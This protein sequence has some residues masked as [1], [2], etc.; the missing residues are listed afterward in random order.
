MAKVIF[1]NHAAVVVSRQEQ[2]TIRAFYCGVLGFKAIRQTDDKDDF[3][4]GDDEYFHITIL[5]GEFAD[6]SEFLRSGR[7]IYLELKADD[8]E[9]MR[10]KIIDS[11]VRT[12]E[13]PDPHLYFQA[14]GGQ[15]FRL[16]GI[17]EELTKYERD[18]VGDEQRNEELVAAARRGAEQLSE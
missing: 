12:I 1:G 4:L 8:V 15:V 2:D 16:V 18:I 17:N 13:M 9:A 5:Y 6:Q 11:G 3:Q 10:Q 7:S 14:P